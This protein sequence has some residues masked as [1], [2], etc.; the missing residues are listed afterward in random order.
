M[1]QGFT[2]LDVEDHLKHLNLQHINCIAACPENHTY[3]Q[4][5]NLSVQTILHA[6]S[7]PPCQFFTVDN[8]R[9]G[10]DTVVQYMPT[11]VLQYMILA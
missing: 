3:L 1:T 9:E 8:T 4:S 7:T 5:G 2:C 11:I 6:T 10:I